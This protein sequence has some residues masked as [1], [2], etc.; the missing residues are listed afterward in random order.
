MRNPFL[1][2]LLQLQQDGCQAISAPTN[3]TQAPPLLEVPTE[4]DAIV[5]DLAESCLGGGPN[6]TFG[7][8]HFFIGSP[9]NGKSAAVGQLVRM[10]LHDHHCKIV[11]DA[12][13][14][15]VTDIRD[16]NAN[17]VPYSLSVF[18]PDCK[19]PSVRIVQDASVVRRPFA[20]DV[21]PARDL[22]DT[23]SEAWELGI[24]LIVCTN[25]GVLE[26]AFRDTYLDRKVNQLPW[27][28]EI[29]RRLA[30]SAK[31]MKLSQELHPSGRHALF[32]SIK[33]SASFLDSRSLI[34]TG[35]G[36]FDGIIQKA[37]HNDN[38]S[39]CDGC[40]HAALCPF[41]A[42]RDWL[43]DDAGRNQVVKAFRRAEV[44]SSQVIVFREALAAISF[45]LAGCARDYHDTDPCGW[46]RE[47]VARGDIFGLATRRVYMALFSSGFPRGL[48]VSR[49]LRNYQVKALKALLGKMPNG[50]AKASLSAA[51]DTPAPS[52][53]V[54]VPRLLGNNGV[55]SNL[56]PV[57]GPL[58]ASFF[59]TWDGCYDKIRA[60]QPPLYSEIERRCV[61][62][63]DA[64]E[65]AVENMPS[66]LDDDVFTADVYWAVRRWSTQFTL[67]LGA[68]V[69]GKAYLAEPVDE[70]AELLELFSKDKDARTDDERLRL[71]VLKNLVVRIINHDVNPGREVFVKLSE[72]VKIGGRWVEIHMSPS[73]EA[74]SASGSLTIDVLFGSSKERTT[75]TASMYLWLKQRASGTMDSRCV[76]SDLLNEAMNAKG[77]AVAKSKYAFASD[78]ITLLVEGER[79]SFT[80]TR[81]DGEVNVNAH[82]P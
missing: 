17:S 38:W 49:E 15:N 30:D 59:D 63:W 75:L 18:K 78:D 71:G 16:L 1:L 54:G 53:D 48:E 81:Y 51:L 7:R 64:L 39:A 82:K 55:F 34:L 22:L 76:P 14:D 69:E 32:N 27:H 44:L 10:L 66:H 19:F 31:G 60:L 36:I 23:L 58:P 61:N 77:R 50:D 80:L 74:S 62:V 11:D 29:L 73:V 56:D 25:R 65:K 20:A 72:N 57:R 4:L 28:K 33:A 37:V 2:K 26:K 67:H 46:V 40:P 12:D 41:K 45:L 24:S 5:E 35:R 47:M 79:E 8:W 68:L 3:W 21:D 70:F 6:G 13:P 43:L 52:T 9:G 42:N